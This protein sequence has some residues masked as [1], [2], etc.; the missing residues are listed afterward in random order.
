MQRNLKAKTEMQ[1]FKIT[2]FVAMIALFI[3]INSAF[4]GDPMNSELKREI[5]R[6]ISYPSGLQQ[7]NSQEMVWVRFQ[8]E[9]CGLITILD[10]DSSNE[11]FKS[12]VMRKLIALRFSPEEFSGEEQFMKFTF[13]KENA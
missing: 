4:A 6:V 11:E 12:Y 1:Q 10:I 8:V 13:K 9:S 2:F 3:G 5:S 7:V